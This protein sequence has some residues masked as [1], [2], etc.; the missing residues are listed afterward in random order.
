M[1]LVNDWKQAWR[2]I[3]VN[4]MI[5]AGAIQAA[6]MSISDDMKAVIPHNMVEYVTIALLLFGVVG[7]LVKQEPK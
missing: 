2:W 5:I 1:K 6:W 4:C 7:R 3:S